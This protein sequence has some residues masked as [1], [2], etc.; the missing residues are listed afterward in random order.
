[1][2]IP[3]ATIA[4][5]TIDYERR[6]L[7]KSTGF[8]EY[9]A[10]WFYEREINLNG[11]RAVG[12]GFGTLLHER[13]I[14]PQVVT[15][16]DFRAYSAAVRHALIVGLME[17][18]CAVHDIGLAL[19]PMAYFAQF[20]LGVEA[21]AMVTASHNENGWTGFKLGMDPRVTLGPEDMAALKAIVLSGGGRAREGGRFIEVRGMADTYMADLA[22]KVLI[23]KPLKVVCACGN[24]TAGAF[25]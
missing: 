21:V 24:G 5:N 8:R 2:D 12:L 14:A 9:D 13:G 10:R 4:P 15:G 22:A 6:A 19:S 20:A 18:G 16:H 1:M 3:S 11:V 17:A 25:A 7:I 23:T